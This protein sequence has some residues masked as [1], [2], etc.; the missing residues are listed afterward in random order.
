MQS[1]ISHRAQVCGCSQFSKSSR[2]LDEKREA[3]HGKLQVLGEGG[4]EKERE[5]REESEGEINFPLE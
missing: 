3:V 2:I 1:I 4:R 5:S